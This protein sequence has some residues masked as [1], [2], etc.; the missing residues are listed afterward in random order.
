MMWRCCPRNQREERKNAT[1]AILD[2]IAHLGLG[3]GALK[4]CGDARSGTR[5]G[6]G[7]VAH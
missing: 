6:R 1:A 4:G 5:E 2:A 3:L 7:M